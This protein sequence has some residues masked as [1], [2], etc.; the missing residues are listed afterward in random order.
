MGLKQWFSKKI[1]SDIKAASG[2]SERYPPRTKRHVE[3]LFLGGNPD[4][5]TEFD[6]IFFQNLDATSPL[7]LDQERIERAQRLSLLLYRKNVRAFCAIELVKDFALGDGIRF[8]ANDPKVQKLLEEHWEVN[9]WDDKLAERVRALAIFGE[10]IYPAF[11]NSTTGMVRLSSVAPLRLIKVNRNTK[12]AED[13]LSIS[14]SISNSDDVTDESKD[15]IEGFKVKE[16]AIIQHN[17]EI[18]IDADVDMPPS[19]YFT[20]NRISGST[21]GLPDVLS[22]IDWLEGL[23]GLIFSMLERAEISQDVV[24]DLQFDG[25]QAKEL[26]KEA[27]KFTASLRS[28]E[29]WAHNEKAQMQIQAP[30]L[31]SSEGEVIVSILLRQIQAG[32]RLAG[33]FFG[34]AED[35]TRA[36]ASELATPVAKAIQGRQNFI[37]SMIS[38]VF[39]FQI[40]QAQKADMLSCVTDFGF[41]IVMPL[42]FLRD[43]ATITESLVNLA[44]ALE[45]AVSNDWIKNKQAG[46]VYRSS[47]Q[48]LGLTID[49]IMEEADGQE[50]ESSEEDSDEEA[51]GVSALGTRGGADRGIFDGDTDGSPAPGTAGS[52]HDNGD[53]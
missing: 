17:G 23:D 50:E 32:T 2:S 25:L 8:K 24:F 15:S 45:S 46:A 42:V 51:E 28:G 31:G 9:A 53:G 33:L 16:F 22:A 29:A 37:K 39:R 49:D 18:S 35:L 3:Q 41:E 30:N 6:D 14:V 21:R 5:G 36:S 4:S 26:K 44:S 40:K 38:R 27:D 7:D 48:Q 47:L 52:S 34:D 13:L 12:D 11:V 20:I 19:F 43:I 10:Q 1:G